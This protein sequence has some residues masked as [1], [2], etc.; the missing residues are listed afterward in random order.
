MLIFYHS[1]FTCYISIFYHIWYLYIPSIL[2]TL[3]QQHVFESLSLRRHLT[4][5]RDPPVRYNIIAPHTGDVP[6]LGSVLPSSFC[7]LVAWDCLLPGGRS[8]FA[9]WT[10]VEFSYLIEEYRRLVQVDNL[11]SWNNWLQFFFNDFLNL[12]KICKC[13]WYTPSSIGQFAKTFW[14]F[15]FKIR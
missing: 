2:L 15:I 3:R 8:S 9:V 7:T 13:I 1:F 5:D 4:R 14:R 12:T 10:L 11:Y 6:G